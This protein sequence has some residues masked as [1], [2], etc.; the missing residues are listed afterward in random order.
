MIRIEEILLK[1]GEA[2]ASDLHLTVG[3]SPRMRVNGSLRP[4]DYP[5][6]EPE[7]T[8]EAAG[9]VM[10]AEQMDTLKERGEY[11][12]AFSIPGKGRYR[13]NAFRQRGTVALAFRLV[14]N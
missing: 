10:S 8:M 4:M 3:L 14:A 11:D 9:C 13:V 5:V 6:L 12:L 1:A 2:G 7:D